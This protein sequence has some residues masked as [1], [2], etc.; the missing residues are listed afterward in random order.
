V[1]VYVM[2]AQE[3]EGYVAHFVLD[4]SEGFGWF[5][6]YASPAERLMVLVA[7]SETAETYEI[8]L[9]GV[10]Y[11]ND[12][13]EQVSA[14]VAPVDVTR[15]YGEGSV[16]RAEWLSSLDAYSTP[17]QLLESQMGWMSR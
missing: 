17:S 7:T 6:S 11:V 4:E 9:V 5:G 16:Q 1:D 3:R 12:A 2:P 14:I 10:D 15:A 13:G 8:S